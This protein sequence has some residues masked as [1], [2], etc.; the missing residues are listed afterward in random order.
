M[1]GV[2]SAAL[3]AVELEVQGSG[4]LTLHK[5]FDAEENDLDAGFRLT[6]FGELRGRGC[7]VPLDALNRLTEGVNE[8]T[9][10]N[11]DGY[12]HMNRVG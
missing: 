4:N 9:N 8:E 12:S 11:G 2:P 7:K 1:E 6:K 3:Q 5:P 10:G